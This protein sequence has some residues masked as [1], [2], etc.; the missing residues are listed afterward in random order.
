MFI[1]SL[2]YIAPLE[3]MDKHFPEHKEF[4]DSNYKRNIF[5]VSGRKVPR[6]GGIIVALGESKEEIQKIIQNDPYH[7]LELAKYTI[8]EFVGSNF[9][10]DLARLLNQ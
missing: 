3:Q 4:L 8:T 5:L 10:P 1:I 6:T 2:D 7:K 9:H